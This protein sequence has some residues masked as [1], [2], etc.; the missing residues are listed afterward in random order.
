[1]E[2]ENH[3]TGTVKM[4]S[5][6]DLKNRYLN[7]TKITV[8]LVNS[9]GLWESQYY[10]LVSSDNA[11]SAFKSILDYFE[12]QAVE[13][14]KKIHLEPMNDSCF[15]LSIEGETEYTIQ[16]FVGCAII[17]NDEFNDAKT[18]HSVEKMLE[19]MMA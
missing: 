17:T 14:K 12:Q 13:N 4:L 10:C 5:P 7:V 9:K 8:Y 6:D 15:K 18:E 3:Y 16:I 19:S 11:E 2:Q 1:M